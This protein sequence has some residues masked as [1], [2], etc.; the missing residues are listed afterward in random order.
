MTGDVVTS[1][2]EPI[3]LEDDPAFDVKKEYQDELDYYYE[4]HPNDKGYVPPKSLKESAVSFLGGI[5]NG[6]EKVVEVRDE[7]YGFNDKTKGP[8]I[9]LKPVEEMEFLPGGIG[10]SD[11]NISSPFHVGMPIINPDFRMHSQTKKKST[12]D[13]KTNCK[14]KK[15][16]PNCCSC[17]HA[18]CLK[19]PRRCRYEEKEN[20]KGTSSPE[21]VFSSD[22]FGIG[23]GKKLF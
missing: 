1:P 7:L 21:D 11:G 9:H 19:N 22:P 23:K 8:R 14:K 5:R 4:T 16:T 17:N 20:E 2:F 18:D 15:K 12:G 6:L 3:V 10:G 13:S